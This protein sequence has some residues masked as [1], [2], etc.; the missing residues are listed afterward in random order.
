MPVHV[1]RQEKELVKIPLLYLLP[2]FRQLMGY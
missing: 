1:K 2:F